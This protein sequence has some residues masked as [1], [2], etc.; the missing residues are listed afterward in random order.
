MGISTTNALHG[1]R[2][3]GAFVPRPNRFD[4]ALRF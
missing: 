2:A 3:S 1:K 4:V